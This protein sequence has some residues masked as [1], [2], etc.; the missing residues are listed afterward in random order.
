MKPSRLLLAVTPL[1][2]ALLFTFAV[3]TAIAGTTKGPAA[4]D[5]RI[6]IKSVDA[7]AGTVEFEYM[8]NKTTHV[9]KIDGGST[10]KVNDASGTITDIKPGMQVRDSAERDSDTLDSISVSAADPAPPGTSTSKKKKT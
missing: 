1:A 10:V 8:T 7:T 9:Y 5:P 3:P 2:L 4:D 6:L